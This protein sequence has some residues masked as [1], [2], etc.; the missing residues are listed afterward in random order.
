MILK[1]IPELEKI[2]KGILRYQEPLS[3]HTTFRLGGMADIF[4]I[5]SSL[6]EI[7]EI[8]EFANCKSIPLHVIGMG[9][10]LLIS[11]EG[12]RGIVLK[13]ASPLDNISFEEDQVLVE[14]GAKCTRLIADAL[15]NQLT[16]LS[17]LSG[18]PGTIGGAIAMNAGTG[19]KAI[20]DILQSVWL[21]D[22]V[23][24]QNCILFPADLNFAYRDSIFKKGD[25]YIIL[26]AKLMINQGNVDEEIKIIR[27]KLTQRKQTQPLRYPNAGCIWK[28]PPGYSTGKLIEELGLKGFRKGR[29]KISELHANFIVHQGRAKAREVLELINY[30][31]EKVFQTYQIELEREIKI[32]GVFG[33]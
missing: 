8:V 28:N 21:Y 19:G 24:R 23:E 32:L 26:Q 10:N 2:V 9:S 11:D 18:I 3:N 17:F 27:E 25:R 20:G 29:A 15:K 13:L 31:E 7:Q 16:G 30:I 22:G 4:I 14:A 33:F 1:T 5:P 12:L 6:D